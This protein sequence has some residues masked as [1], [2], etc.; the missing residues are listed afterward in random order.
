MQR[1]KGKV[2]VGK[3]FSVCKK[4]DETKLSDKFLILCVKINGETNVLFS[5]EGRFLTLSQKFFLGANPQTSIFE[6]K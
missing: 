3:S 2:V 5:V 6:K 4:F 1:Q